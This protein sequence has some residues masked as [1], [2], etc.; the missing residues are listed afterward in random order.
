MHNWKK[1]AAYLLFGFL[2]L[3][4]IAM[5][6][7]I[8]QASEKRESEAT[9]EA[10]D[11]RTA[12]LKSQNE[13]IEAQRELVNKSDQIAQLN[14]E[15]AASVTGSGEFAYLA[16]L[17]AGDAQQHRLFLIVKHTGKYPIYDVGFRV[18]DL[19]VGGSKPYAEEVLSNTF[20]VGNLAARQLRFVAYWPLVP[21]IGTHYGYNF[22]FTARNASGFV[23]QELRYIKVDNKWLSATRV[24]PFNSQ[25]ILYEH[26]DAGFPRKADGQ[27]EWNNDAYSN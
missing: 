22:F 11:N 21:P 6:I 20:S 2:A 5:G 26:T 16:P 10:R 24:K 25:R 17:L 12:L 3:A 18:L 19:R 15:I 8:D 13:V 23:I 9:V 7:R 14:K 1:W 4:Y 27:I